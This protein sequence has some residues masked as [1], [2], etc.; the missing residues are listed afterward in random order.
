MALLEVA[1]LTPFATIEAGKAAAMVA[2]AIAMACLSAPCLVDDL[3]LTDV[4]VAAAKAILRGAV[5]RWHE[6]GSASGALSSQTM[7]PFSM[8]I[9]TRMKRRALFWPSEVVEL[10]HICPDDSGAFSI[11]TA[12]P[13]PM[14]FHAVFCTYPDSG[15]CV[16]GAI[17]FDS[18]NID[19]PFL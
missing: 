16:C 7:G 6:A 9:D 14:L 2:D 19:G 5:L 18:D 1:D 17:A 13:S 15:W 3:S 4:Q 12:P 8:A 10:Q 11:D